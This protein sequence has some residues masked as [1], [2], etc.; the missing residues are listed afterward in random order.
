MTPLGLISLCLSVGTVT[1]SCWSL[2]KAVGYLQ[3]STTLIK[4][5]L[6]RLHERKAEIAALKEI[7]VKEHGYDE[8]D[9][10]WMPS[11][12]PGGDA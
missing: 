12:G 4:F 5:L 7:L 2:H 10:E 8:E 1:F 11:T 6:G 9:L 3:E